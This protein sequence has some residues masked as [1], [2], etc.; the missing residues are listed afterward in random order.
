MDGMDD[1]DVFDLRP[2]TT[3]K[4]KTAIKVDQSPTQPDF[5]FNVDKLFESDQM[6]ML[7]KD[8][9]GLRDFQGDRRDTMKPERIDEI[10]RDSWERPEVKRVLETPEGIWPIFLVR[11]HLKKF[12]GIQEV[13]EV[14]DMTVD[15]DANRKCFFIKA[16]GH[17]HD[18]TAVVGQGLETTLF[19]AESEDGYCISH[20]TLLGRIHLFI[21]GEV[22][23]KDPE[24]KELVEIKCMAESTWNRP[25]SLYY[26]YVQS[27][28]V[29]LNKIIVYQRDDVMPKLG[30][31]CKILRCVPFTLDTL[32][33]RLKSKYPGCE[34]TL[35]FAV[36]RAS[37]CLEYIQQEFRDRATF[38]IQGTA[39]MNVLESLC[40]D[41]VDVPF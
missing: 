37:T 39:K 11:N 12:L 10:L 26:P 8:W 16:A 5:G 24:S 18:A 31:R 2:N 40:V 1:D 6:P 15:V 3:V 32:W 13:E 34:D 7:R 36:S 21:Y 17:A 30:E 19:G 25:G 23:G 38:E 4:A 22:D 14:F 28:L 27:K 33:E 41:K 35:K 20:V 29:N 9:E